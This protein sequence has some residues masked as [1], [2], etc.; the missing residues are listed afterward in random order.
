MK[1]SR[2][3]SP[4]LLQAEINYNVSECEA[5]DMIF[6]VRVASFFYFFNN[7]NSCGSW[8]I[9]NMINKSQF[10]IW[11]VRW[12]VFLQEFNFTFEVRPSKLMLIL[13]TFLD[14]KSNRD[15]KPDN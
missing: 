3:A 14:I 10:S 7:K 2:P 5:L 11:I 6:S 1:K 4:Q 15:R 13:T 12:V 9:E 8:C